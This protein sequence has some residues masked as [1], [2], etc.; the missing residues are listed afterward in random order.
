M[1]R[2]VA[3][4][5]GVMQTHQAGDLIGERYRVVGVLGRGGVGTTYEAEVIATGQRVAVKQLHLWH[6][7]GDWKGFELFQR[8][9]RVLAGLQ[10]PAIPRYL[11]HLQIELPSG[12][13]FYL[14]QELAPGRTLRKLLDEGWRPT[15]AEVRVLA[16]QLLGVLDY[17]HS[18]SPP[19]IHRDLK[20]ENVLRS[21]DGRLFLVDFGAVRDTYRTLSQGSTVVGTFGYMAPEQF[22]GHAVPATDLYGLGALLMTL[23]TR[24]PPSEI[25]QR[26]GKPD[27]RKHAKLTPGFA[28]WLD[29]MLEAEP[30]R[31]FASARQARLRLASP[32]PRL[33]VRVL[34]LAIILA[35][36]SIVVPAGIWTYFRFKHGRLPAVATG[37]PFRGVDA[38]T[39]R[40]RLKK[41][42]AA[43]WS[44]VFAVAFIDDDRAVSASNDGAVKMWNLE[45][46]ELIRMFVGHQGRVSAAAASADKRFLVTGGADGARV[47]AVETG[48]LERRLSGEPGEVMSVAV[49]SKGQV[50]AGHGNGNIALY[51]L[52][53]GKLTRTLKQT[54]L[55]YS[56]QFT[57]DGERLFSSGADGIVHA[58][59]LSTG[60]GSEIARHA[61]PIT[62]IAVSPDGQTLASA[63]DDHS[64]KV[65]AI[66]PRKLLSSYD[67]HHDEMWSAGFSPN[68]KLLAVAGR[69]GAIEVWD[70]YSTTLLDVVTSSPNGVLRVRFS[71]NGKRLIA[72]TGSSTVQVFDYREPSWRPPLVSEPVAKT[73]TVVD[74]NAPEAVKLS[75]QAEDILDDAETRDA[76]DRAE[77]LLKR[78]LELDPKLALVHAS[79]AR[80]EYK[81]G[82]RQTDEYDPQRLK[83]AHR[84]VD[85]A[86]ELDPKSFEGHLRRAFIYKFEKNYDAAQKE[87]EL[88]RDL[89]P[90]DARGHLCLM[91][92]ASQRR[93]FAEVLTYARAVLEKTKDRQERAGAYG[94][95]LD[96]YYAEKEWDAAD[97]VHRSLMN[98][99]PDSAWARGNYA[100]F[101]N[102]RHR[103]DDAIKWATAALAM[104]RYPAAEIALADAHAGKA[105]DLLWPKN[106][107]S[108]NIKLASQSIDAALQ[109]SNR[110]ADAHYARGL[111]ALR[112]NDMIGPKT[113]FAR[114]LQIEP[115]HSM[116]K[117]ALESLDA[118][119]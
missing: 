68:G 2:R 114:A 110:S 33:G 104:R 3:A 28:S 95:L 38:K 65:W 119:K 101:L 4:I 102:R 103:W 40:L 96:V 116:A 97:E 61:K 81:R 10:H 66:R 30:E 82:F 76:Y 83:A 9:G 16:E 21:D 67:D 70:V 71:P 63:S 17:L 44:A 25:A 111:L 52:G 94:G 73:P 88:A 98:L 42:L 35:L 89:S 1:D 74:P 32:G 27:F 34:R 106:P 7:E 43:H 78:A 45:S 8:E 80:L 72:G 113:H 118:K 13:C 58:W 62:E 77:A 99:D 54:G 49:S 117:S 11:E 41:T 29:T 84:H 86:L 24:T 19:V 100:S 39:G 112:R 79:L 105:I 108:E 85:R 37:L 14:V 48:A 18:L 69:E 6:G 47:W 109:A 92:L 36:V 15:E 60:E 12:P 46:G 50:A 90:D 5:R 55:V 31:R 59:N 23:V 57:P 87:A 53:D 22:R 107:S 115:D 51:D 64:V 93:K 56:V 91:E 20:P 26:K 75:L